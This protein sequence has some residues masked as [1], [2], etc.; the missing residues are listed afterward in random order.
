MNAALAY[1]DDRLEGRGI[2]LTP[3]GDSRRASQAQG[4]AAFSNRP[5]D[6]L[7]EAV[8][9]LL[10]LLRL[11]VGWDGHRGNPTTV[12]SASYALEVLGRIMRPGVPLPSI[13]PLSNGGVQL[14]WHRKGWDVEV[15]IVG[16]RKVDVFTHNLASGEE[17]ELEINAD[18]S[19]LSAV[20]EQIRD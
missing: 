7:S 5:P 1:R 11:P 3:I 10:T 16:G 14:E 4:S 17:A 13:M 20:V 2:T 19:A 8:E 18:L 6:W 15:E 12:A 9:R